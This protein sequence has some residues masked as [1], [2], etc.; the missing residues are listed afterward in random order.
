MQGHRP[1]LN[2]EGPIAP[3]RGSDHVMLDESRIVMHVTV[4]FVLQFFSERF[5]FDMSLRFH[6]G[7]IDAFADS[8]SLCRLH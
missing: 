3:A 5:R 8:R 4:S 1:G 2:I 7:N 6:L